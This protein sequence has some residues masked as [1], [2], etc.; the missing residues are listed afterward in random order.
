MSIPVCLLFVSKDRL[1]LIN[2]YTAVK[3]IILINIYINP[4][5]FMKESAEGTCVAE[6]LTSD[7]G[8]LDVIRAEEGVCLYV[9]EGSGGSCTGV[10]KGAPTALLTALYG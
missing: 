4:Q 10:M 5:Y 9:L 6:K 3:K 2:H 1:K 7:K 8:L